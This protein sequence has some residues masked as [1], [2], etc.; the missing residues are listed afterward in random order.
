MTLTYRALCYLHA[1]DHK[2]PIQNG[3]ALES[4]LRTARLDYSV[5]SLERIDV[6]LDA[7]RTT[8]KIRQD[9]D[10]DD[11]AKQN[12]LYL[13]AFYVGEVIGRSLGAAP[14][15][16]SYEEMAARERQVNDPHFENSVTLLFA[17][18][19]T[20]RTA[21]LLPLASICSRLFDR[22]VTKSVLFSA[23]LML[24]PESLRK[25]AALRPLPP[26]VPPAWPVA[27][28]PA[29]IDAPPWAAG[30]D[31][32]YLFDN[33]QSMLREGRVV[34]GAVVQANNA[35]FQ[36]GP[37][38]GAPG[39]ILYD[40]QGRVPD[41]DLHAMARMLLSLKGRRPDVPELAS[42]AQYLGDEQVRVFGLDLPPSISPYPLKV[43][44]TWFDRQHLPG[45]VLAQPLIPVLVSDAHPGA[46]LPLPAGSWP[47]NLRQAWSPAGLQP[48][49]DSPVVEAAP[50]APVPDPEPAHRQPASLAGDGPQRVRGGS[51]L[52]RLLKR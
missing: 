23:G 19:L 15:W 36:P 1:F 37:M 42:I 40:P 16:A 24:P 7:L 25:P 8:G 20:P 48:M 10:L 32:H 27:L 39:E 6:L 30:D 33:A 11:P 21:W 9:D 5:Q 3:L 45:G 31:L 2:L 47:D 4:V 18:G 26:L 38:A 29:V 12:L 46:V 51:L 49:A 22:P 13:L 34:W 44:S 14:Q 52:G 35:L 17:P 41:A 43:S 28:A 50:A